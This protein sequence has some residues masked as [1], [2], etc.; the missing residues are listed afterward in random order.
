MR[1]TEFF[2]IVHEKMKERPKINDPKLYFW[3]SFIAVVTLIH[4][5]VLCFHVPVFSVISGWFYPFTSKPWGPPWLILSM[6]GLSAVV[7]ALI[8][9]KAGGITPKLILLIILGFALQQAFALTEGRGIEAIRDR[10]VYTGHAEFPEAAVHQDNA[11]WMVSNYEH[12]ADSRELKVSARAKPPGQLLLYIASERIANLINPR[13]TPEARLAWSLTFAAYV[14]PLFCYL[15]VIPMFFLSWSLL[16]QERA[17]G[18]CVLFLYVPSVNLIT[19][20]TDQAFFPLFF[21]TCLLCANTAFSRRSFCL[22]FL[23][24]LLICWVV[25]LSFG[26][27]PIF[28]FV[29]ALGL[30]YGLTF[31]P[32][33]VNIKLICKIALGVILGLVVADMFLRGFLN[34]DIFVRYR[35]ATSVLSE[36][37]SWTWRPKIVIGSGIMNLLEFTVWVGFPLAI[38]CGL[39]FFRSVGSVFKGSPKPIAFINITLFTCII[40]TTF[41]GGTAG[42]YSRYLIYMVPLVCMVAAD[43]IFTGFSNIRAPIMALILILQAGTV[44]FTKVFQDFY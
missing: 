33:R 12:L 13:T 31:R 32:V 26:L 14:W 30:L 29:G 11:A 6:V 23:T 38:L 42:E 36:W 2:V 9:R 39:S 21:T 7:L 3:V 18:A 22:A 40:L 1:R 25:F 34:Y 35:K 27:L 28:F 15:A 16:D 44:Y 20:H 17:L 10:M 24:G 8:L 41:L 37:K 19:L 4:W 5:A 43:E